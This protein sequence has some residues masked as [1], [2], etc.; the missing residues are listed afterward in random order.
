MQRNIAVE[1]SCGSVLKLMVM[2]AFFI[3][4]LERRSE[5]SLSMMSVL[6]WMWRFTTVAGMMA[7]VVA[8]TWFPSLNLET[9]CLASSSW[10]H[11][12]NLTDC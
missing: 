5:M 4:S 9:F 6:I 1:D 7:E 10:K 12:Q 2:P 8:V 11:D 3:A